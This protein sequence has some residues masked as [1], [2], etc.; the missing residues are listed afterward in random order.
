[1]D[2]LDAMGIGPTPNEENSGLITYIKKEK[3]GKILV[4]R[5]DMDL[6]PNTEETGAAYASELG[7]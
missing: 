5:A 3:S 7:A 4:F 1:M 6:L 2:R